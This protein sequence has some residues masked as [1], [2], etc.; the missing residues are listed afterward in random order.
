MRSMPVVMVVAAG[1]LLLTAAPAAAAPAT[2]GGCRAFGA[3]V[4]TLG[5]ELGPVFGAT[6]SGVAQA[7]P[8]AFPTLVVFPEQ[9]AL[10]R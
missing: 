3:N 2:E 7:F 9:D 6:A 5:Q 4:A 1:G 8:R 10:C